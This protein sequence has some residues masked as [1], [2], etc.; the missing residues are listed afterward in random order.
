LTC[1]LQKKEG[2][3][4]QLKWT[5]RKFDFTQ[6]I[7]IFPMVLER[8]R[9]VP[10]RLG[11]YAAQ[12]SKEELVRQ[13]KGAWSVQEHIGH[14]IDLEELHD[15]RIDDFLSGKEVLRAADM[16]NKRTYEAG[17]NK[18][19]CNELLEK[20][21][22]VRAAFVKRLEELDERTVSRSALHPRL[23]VPMRPCDMALFTAEHDDHHL[24]II[25]GLYS[26]MK[27]E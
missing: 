4:Q 8:L 22:K 13:V 19:N 14:L 15:G 18:A 6:P 3:I 7:G 11:N 9:G 12:L 24:A 27:G 21:E 1:I 5:E 17:H 25:Y 20:F 26:G 23:N 10:L 16:Q 2:M